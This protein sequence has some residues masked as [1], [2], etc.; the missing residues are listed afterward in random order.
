MPIRCN[1]CGSSHHDTNQCPHHP[2]PKTEE[3]HMLQEGC[4]QST[5][6][7][8]F[9]YCSSE[10]FDEEMLHIANDCSYKYPKFCIFQK[11]YS[12]YEETK[13]EEEDEDEYEPGPKI[14]MAQNQSDGDAHMLTQIKA[15]LEGEMKVS[16][17]IHF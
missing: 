15:F 5:D 4:C 8:E 14:Y 11:E 13:D 3:V 2:F 6:T 9:E 16:F 12:S 1:K 17:Y 10:S 7:S